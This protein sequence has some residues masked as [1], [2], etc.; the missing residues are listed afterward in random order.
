[1]LAGAGGSIYAGSPRSFM[2]GIKV[3]F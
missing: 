2:G 3:K 1:V